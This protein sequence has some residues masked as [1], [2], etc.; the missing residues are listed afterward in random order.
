MVHLTKFQSITKNLQAERLSTLT[1]R[2]VVDAL[3]DD[4]EYPE[5][6]TKLA[7]GSDIVNNPHF[8][9]GFNKIIGRDI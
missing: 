1:V 4:N 5:I 8:E 9:S 6:Q 3:L 7:E 2:E